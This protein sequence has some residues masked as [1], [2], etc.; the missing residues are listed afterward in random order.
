MT[1]LQRAARRQQRC[2]NPKAE[3]F[4]HE[5]GLVR[6]GSARVC[7]WKP[8]VC[9]FELHRDAT[10]RSRKHCN[11]LIAGAD[12]D[13]SSCWRSRR[14]TCRWGAHKLALLARHKSF[15]MTVLVLAA[16][17]LPVAAEEFAS[18]TALGHDPPWSG[19]LARSTHVAFYVLL[20]AMP[21]TGWL[22]SSAKNYSVSWFG[23]FTW[24]NLIGKRNEAAFDLFAHDASH[25]RLHSFRDCG[26]AHSRGT[27]ASFLEQGRRGCCACC[28]SPRSTSPDR[29]DHDAT[30][31]RIDCRARIDRGGGPTA[32]EPRRAIQPTR[33]KSRLEFVGVQAGAEF[34]GVF[35]KF[36]RGP[37]NLRRMRSASSH[38]DVQIDL[39]SVDS[40]DKG[41][42]HHDTR[43][44]HFSTWRTRLRR[45]TS[46][47]ASPRRRRGFAAV[48]S[49]DL[50]RR[51][52]GCADRFPGSH[53]LRTVR[54]SRGA[55]NSSV[56]ILARGQGDWKST[57]WVADA[58]K[59][60]FH[61][62]A[63]AQ[64]LKLKPARFADPTSHL[65]HRQLARVL[66]RAQRET[67]MH[68]GN[69]RQVGVRC[70]LWSRSKS[71]VSA[72]TTRSR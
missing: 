42:R 11:W 5:Q 15:G 72:S 47:A 20:F 12:R 63:Q 48:R 24:P 31:R 61:S 1:G 59:V 32:P 57:E 6:L 50:A 25:P 40:M 52:Q 37:S 28:P 3:V 9:Q 69:I 66:H 18:R 23:L 65:A 51:D 10:Q 13:A 45:T 33:N 70:W 54:S 38:I 16:L 68:P 30:P 44:R 8:A 14:T 56:W 62:G 35:H 58:V 2:Q 4:E 17:R 55:P 39:N 19:C 22:M 7:A 27:E 34:K 29:R 36:Y 41:P 60:S 64:R 71:A 26:I 67:R 53:R 43:C 46:L 49:A 21:M